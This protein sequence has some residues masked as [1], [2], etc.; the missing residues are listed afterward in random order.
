MGPLAVRDLDLDLDAF[1]GPF[2]LLLTLVLKEELALSE[3]E[4]AEIVVTFA[5]RLLGEGPDERH[6]VDLAPPD[7]QLCGEF[8]VLVAALLE[9]K[10]R[11]LFAEDDELDLEDFDPDDAAAELAERLA[12]YR[13]VKAGATWL[14]ERLE[15][16]SDRFFR[17]GPAPLAPAPVRPLA[18]QD[19]QRLAA[20]L[21]VLAT[22]PPA[23]SLAHLA[24]KL[25]PLS[26][27]LERFRAALRRRRQFV[28]DE[29]VDGLS[30]I[31]QAVAFL[32]LLELRKTGE[33][34]LGQPAPFE[35]ISVWKA[36]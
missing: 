1:E 12:A 28:F 13:R 36:A 24:L 32:A 33:I 22:E 2:D 10:A 16:E 19:P 26:L 25:P 23:P 30:R 34:R 27:F 11:E 31:E 9:L 18:P 29:E 6:G 7:L 17:L 35:P 8:L 21:R 14:E 15:A 4:I 20:A 3:V 5:Q